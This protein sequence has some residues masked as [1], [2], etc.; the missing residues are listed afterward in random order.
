MP[1][2]SPLAIAS[3]SVRRLLKEESTYHKELASQEAKIKSFEEAIKNGEGNEDGNQEWHLKQEVRLS[4]AALHRQTG[5][6][7]WIA[8]D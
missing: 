2:P 4:Y 5:Q 3:S 6:W 1:P 8:F 7:S